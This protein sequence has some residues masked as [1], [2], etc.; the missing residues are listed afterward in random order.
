MCV[1]VKSHF[2]IS[3]SFHFCYIFLRKHGLHCLLQALEQLEV[4]RTRV[5]GQCM[6]A[7]SRKIREVLPF[8]NACLDNIDKASAEVDGVAR[9]ASA[10]PQQV[11]DVSSFQ[12][13]K[14]T[15]LPPPSSAADVV[16]FIICPRS[17]ICGDL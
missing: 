8:V 16:C 5:L 17:C 3:G 15:G 2:R 12:D 11:Q 10:S 13:A 9:A 14:I 6:T 4:E 7:F 1:A